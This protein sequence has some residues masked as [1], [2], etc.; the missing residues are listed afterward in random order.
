MNNCV[1]CKVNK[2]DPKSNDMGLCLDCY[3][4]KEVDINEK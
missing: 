1:K 4:F 2:Q 3:N